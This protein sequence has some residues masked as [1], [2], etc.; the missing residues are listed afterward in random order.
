MDKNQGEHNRLLNDTR[1]TNNDT[2]LSQNN[3]ILNG[4]NVSIVN[5]PLLAL[6][7]ADSAY[8]VQRLELLEAIFNFET[9]NRYMVFT[10]TNG[11]NQYLFKCKEESDCWSRQCCK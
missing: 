2:H 9:K 4:A 5:D 1:A 6:A 8:V 10:K 7:T 11:Y 3:L